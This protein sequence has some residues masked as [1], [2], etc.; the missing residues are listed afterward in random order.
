VQIAAKGAVVAVG[1]VGQ[2]RR[3]RDLPAGR[4]LDQR[5]RQMRLRLEDDAVGDLRLLPPLAILAP[6]LGQVQA[7]AQRQRAALAHRRCLVLDT[8]H[9][10]R[11]IHP[12]SSRS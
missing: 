11:E 12:S 1:H 8:D 6:L 3:L 5:A 7:P 2:D 4:L 9:G 10:W